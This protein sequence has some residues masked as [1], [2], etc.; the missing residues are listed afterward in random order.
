[1]AVIQFVVR[2]LSW[3]RMFFLVGGGGGGASIV[4]RGR[5]DR[6]CLSAAVYS[7]KPVGRP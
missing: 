4:F 2:A 5:I 3:R 6:T 1:M 7:W